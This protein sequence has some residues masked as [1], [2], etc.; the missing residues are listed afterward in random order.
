MLD[1]HNAFTPTLRYGTLFE[2]FFADGG[3]LGNVEDGSIG[4]GMY[5]FKAD[6]PVEYLSWMYDLIHGS[7][8]TN[9]DATAGLGVDLGLPSGKLWAIQN[10]NSTQ[11]YFAGNFFT[12]G[13]AE[14]VDD[15]EPALITP[16]SYEGTPGA[17]L[18]GDTIPTEDVYDAAVNYFGNGWR[19]PTRGEIQELID[20]CDWEYTSLLGFNGYRVKSRVNANSIFIPLAGNIANGVYNPSGGGYYWSANRNTSDNMG[21]MLQFDSTQVRY[22]KMYRDRALPIRAIHDAI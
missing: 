12:W 7:F 19:M 10:V 16:E 15:S 20:N 21:Y 18:E 13:N 8:T 6:E 5:E 11:P 1:I 22:Y 14:G 3:E 9:P 4:A 17:A 2:N